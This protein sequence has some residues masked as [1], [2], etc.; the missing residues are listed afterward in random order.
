MKRISGPDVEVDKFGPGKHGFRAEDLARAGTAVT[1][2]WLDCQQEELASIVEAYGELDQDDDTNVSQVLS[3]IHLLTY[4]Q[5]LQNRE[6]MT[7]AASFSGSFY[8]IG[9][10]SFGLAAVGTSG[11]TQFS[12]DGGE[13]WVSGT[14][15]DGFSGTWRDVV[16]NSGKLLAVGDS[17]QVKHI[18]DH[19]FSQT[20]SNEISG[21]T[22]YYAVEW[23]ET[24][25]VFVAVGDGKVSEFT[26]IGT[27]GATIS[28][29]GAVFRAVATDGESFVAVGDSGR[30]SRRNAVGTWTHATVGA[31]NYDSVAYVE[32]V[33]FVAHANGDGIFLSTDG[34]ASWS[35]VVSSWGTRIVGVGPVCLLI[36]SSTISTLFSGKK[37]ELSTDVGRFYDAAHTV[38]GARYEKVYTGRVYTGGASGIFTKSFRV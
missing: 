10:N 4:R 29:P 19:S 33:G 7:P 35:L 6:R 30:I 2:D 5:A 17:G 28:V 24:A 23:G 3:A 9:A 20:W 14:M 12:H 38:L 36:V 13:S 1:V 32:G 15:P 8:G 18:D 16:G 26:F 25:N 31:A 22:A 11:V 21:G 34:G 27:L 37:L